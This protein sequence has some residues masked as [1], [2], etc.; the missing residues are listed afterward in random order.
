M[1]ADISRVIG[2]FPF[3]TFNDVQP[4]ND[5]IV[6]LTRGNYYGKKELQPILEALGQNDTAIGEQ[7]TILGQNDESIMA[8]I[9]AMKVQLQTLVAQV[10][11]KDERIAELE[12]GGGV[13]VCPALSITVNNLLFIFFNIL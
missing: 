12:Q 1:G 9:N 10:A 4:L 11:E 3:I 6:E 2:V 13:F 8:E 5:L 7:I